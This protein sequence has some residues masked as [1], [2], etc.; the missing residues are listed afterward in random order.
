MGKKLERK[1]T[2]SCERK[3]SKIKKG[4]D[5]EGGAEREGKRDGKDSGLVEIV[6][7]ASSWVGSG[8]VLVHGP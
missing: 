4:N 6:R 3:V 1:A 5:G 7:S 8:F 2:S